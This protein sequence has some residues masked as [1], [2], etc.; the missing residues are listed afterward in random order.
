MPM[1]PST[2]PALRRGS[3]EWAGRGASAATTL[4]TA[5][6]NQLGDALAGTAGNAQLTAS[7]HLLQL[8]FEADSSALSTACR[9]IRVVV[10]ASRICLNLRST[11]RG[12]NDA[13]SDSS[14]NSLT[15]S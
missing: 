6:L 1:T 11:A 4:R 9:V 14:R 3:E 2:S 12:A 8:Q 5:P 13:R 7:L 10:G 15:T